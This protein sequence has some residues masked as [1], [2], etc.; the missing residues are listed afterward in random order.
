MH[1]LDATMLYGPGG[2]GVARYLSERRAWLARSAYYRHTL[3]VPGPF[4]GESGDGELTV[5]TWAHAAAARR[6]PLRAVRW[7]RVM[8]RCAPDIIEAEDPGLV[9]WVAMQTARELGI[10]LIAFCHSDVASF[11]ARRMGAPAAVPVRA[12]LR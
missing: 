2:G 9:G 12:Y 10:P 5:A 3:V 11:V 8:R 1:V 6:W 7:L 4:D